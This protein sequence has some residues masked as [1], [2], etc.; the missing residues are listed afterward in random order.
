MNQRFI[1]KA[2]RRAA[3]HC[4]DSIRLCSNAMYC[5]VSTALVEMLLAAVRV[6]LLCAT[7]F[8]LVSAQVDDDTVLGTGDQYATFMEYQR[9]GWTAYRDSGTSLYAFGPYLNDRH[10]QQN[11]ETNGKIIDLHL[12]FPFYGGLYN[13]TMVSH[14]D[15]AYRDSFEKS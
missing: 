10:L 8:T 14:L 7:V 1:P 12:R 6:A 11:E 2:Q 13:Y 15:C 5:C 4:L 3:P 9:S